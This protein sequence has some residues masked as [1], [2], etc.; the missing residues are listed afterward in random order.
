MKNRMSITKQYYFDFAAYIVLSI[1]GV[2]LLVLTIMYKDLIVPIANAF[3]GY[4]FLIV[5]LIAFT[6]ISIFGFV[7]C[8]LFV[9]DF[10]LV[11]LKQYLHVDG[12]VV[13]FKKNKDTESGVQINCFPIILISGTQNKIIL[14]VNDV[15]ETGE[16]YSF[17][18]LKNTKIAMIDK[19]IN[20][21]GRTMQ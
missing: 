20:R 2:A 18:Y 15:L 5:L 14:K 3:I 10:K 6:F 9:K 19:T 8:S 13:G 1:S 16:T 12:L 21:Y 17:V 4:S 7:K 11:K